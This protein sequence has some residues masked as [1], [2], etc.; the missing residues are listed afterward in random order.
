MVSY[1]FLTYPNTIMPQNQ[2]IYV[3]VQDPSLVVCASHECLGLFLR[4]DVESMVVDALEAAFDHCV[5]LLLCLNNT[6]VQ[7]DVLHAHPLSVDHHV[8]R[9]SLCCVV[10]H[11][12][13]INQTIHL[14]SK[15]HELRDAMSVMLVL[16]DGTRQLLV[17]IEERFQ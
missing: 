12:L 17:E 4:A 9:N 13:L 14:R 10:Y 8:A 1:S 11:V 2:C 7:I 16:E 3:V 6:L 5:F 15:S